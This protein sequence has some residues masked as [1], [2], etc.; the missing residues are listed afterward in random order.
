MVVV[1]VAAPMA[2]LWA[3]HVPR[4]HGGTYMSCIHIHQNGQHLFHA[5]IFEPEASELILVI[6]MICFVSDRL[7]P[8]IAHTSQCYTLLHEEVLN[9]LSSLDAMHLVAYCLLEYDANVPY[10]LY[11]HRHRH[12][13]TSQHTRPQHRVLH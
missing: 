10:L 13:S 9:G 2:R 4:P 1:L 6:Y 8:F 7:G 5:M 12:P 3:V 11:P